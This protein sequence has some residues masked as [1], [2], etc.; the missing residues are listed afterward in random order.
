MKCTEWSKSMHDIKHAILVFLV[1]SIALVADMSQGYIVLDSDIKKEALTNDLE[2]YHMLEERYPILQNKENIV[3]VEG[4]YLLKSGPFKRGDELTL[5]YLHTR[6]AFPQAFILDTPPSV[7]NTPVKVKYITHEVTVEKEDT[8]LWTALFGLAIIGILYMFLSSDQMKN[9]RKQHNKIRNRQVEIEKKQS[10][11]LEKM[12]EKIQTVALKNVN[13]EKKL[14]E[15]AFTHVDKEEM[16]EH[17]GKLKKY[18]EDLLRTTY[19]MIDFLKIKSGNIIIKQEAFQLS[20]ML[21]KLTNAI[22]TILKNKGNSLAYVIDTNVTRYLVGDTERIYQVLDN[23]LKDIVEEDR[24]NELV[25]S[26]GIRKE[27]KLVFGIKNRHKY[28]TQEEIERLFVPTSWEELQQS[29]KTFSF[30]VLR[31]LIENMEGELHVESTRKKGTCY[32]FSLPYIQDIDNKSRKEELKNILRHKKALVVEK[33]EADATILIEILHSFG[34][35]TLLATPY[36]IMNIKSELASIDFLIIKAEDITVQVSNFLEKLDERDK[37]D[38][39]VIKSIVTMDENPELAPSLVDMELFSPL[40]LG[41]VEEV[42]KQLC[43]KKKQTKK[44]VIREDLSHFRITDSAKVSRDDFKKFTTKSILIVEDNLVA[45]QVMGTILSASNLKVYTVENGIQALHFLEAHEHIDL[46]FMD[47]NMPIMDGFEASKKIRKHY[48]HKEVPIV[49][50]TGLGFNYEMEQ[51][52]LSGVNAC[53]IKPFK[54]GHLYVAL[55][56]F[57]K[58][59]KNIQSQVTL[60]KQEYPLHSHILDVKKGIHYVRSETFYKEII[61]QILLTLKNSEQ[62]VQEMIFKNEIKQLRAFCIDSVGLCGTIGATDFVT[63]LNTMLMAIQHEASMHEFI[64]PYKEKW[65]ELEKE[66]RTYLR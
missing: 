63:L 48:V 14:L 27:E 56:R 32:E 6:T 53:I 3:N 21:H 45:Q 47:M 54:V 12:G 34:I 5:A 50:V 61:F 30:F 64:L 9:L 57:L 17:I 58:Q 33:N 22:A 29:N 49:A 52:I 39:I 40:I 25:L 44:E 59:N 7:K 37:I 8:S 36:N 42:L 51:M 18:D 60:K 23:L 46:I 15:S 55:E 11:L 4:M 65:L 20:N 35:D 16:K 28:L 19:E 13:S 26:I 62:L 2:K 24:A 43:I 1:F 41:D 38:I 10:L 66:I 31:E